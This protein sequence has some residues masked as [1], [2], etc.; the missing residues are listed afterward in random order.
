MVWAIIVAEPWTPLSLIAGGLLLV[1]AIG[2]LVWA[3]RVS[4][5]R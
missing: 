5:R 3:F 2:G 1:A 4:A